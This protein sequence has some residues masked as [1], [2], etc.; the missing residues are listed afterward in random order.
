MLLRPN[1]N[2][3]VAPPF[4][5][6][7]TYSEYLKYWYISQDLMGSYYVFTVTRNPYTRIESIYRYAGYSNA[8]TFKRFVMEVV[9]QQVK[10]GSGAFYFYRPQIDF[11]VDSDGEIAVDEVFRVER[12]GEVLSAMNRL[13]I[14]VDALPHVNKTE[15]KNFIK[16]MVRRYR[17]ARRGHGAWSIAIDG[18]VRWDRESREMI[19]E[20]Y[21]SDFDRLGYESIQ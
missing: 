14:D 9:P 21:R 12:L 11:L 15:S 18:E 16:V 7:L 5:A 2:N 8:M 6:H 1:A 4:L 17:L 13:G 19:N 10:P 3:R 20:L